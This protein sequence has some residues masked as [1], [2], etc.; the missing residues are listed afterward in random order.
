M[1]KRRIL[2]ID[3]N[4]LIAMLLA[5]TLTAM[6]YEI[7]GIEGTEQGAV[8]VAQ[9]AKPDVMIVD[10]RLGSGSG[11]AAVEQIERSGPVPHIFVSGDAKKLQL[12]GAAAIV[13]AKPFRE[14]DLAEAIH[15]ALSPASP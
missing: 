4:A 5:E 2:I 8:A 15:R 6:G 9:S 1:T 10:L 12:L 11:V 13:L 14:S 7:C 3:D